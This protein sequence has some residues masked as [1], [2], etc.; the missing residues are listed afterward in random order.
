MKDKKKKVLILRLGAIGD[1]VHTTII[2]EA[3]KQKHP[4][5][6]VHYMTE[7]T[8]SPLLRNNPY[9]DKI[10][11]WDRDKKDS[12]RYYIDFQKKLLKERYDIIF[13]L[14]N[15]IR[16]DLYAYLSFP[17]KVV[18]KKMK[19]GLW[20]EDYFKTAQK[21][22]KDIELPERLYLGV[23]EK[24]DKNIKEYLDAYPKP[25]IMIV[26]GGGT[27]NNRQGRVW[28][29]DNWK[30]LNDMLL[31]EYGGTIFT[32]GSK[33][34]RQLHETLKR[35]GVIICTGEHKLAE[36]SALLSHAD[37]VVSGDTGPLHIASAHNVPTLALL[38]STSPDK[39]KPYGKNGHYISGEGE[40]KY[41]WKKKC[42]YLGQESTYTPCMETISPWMVMDKI[43]KMKLLNCNG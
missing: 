37:L 10:Y 16:N 2:A 32:I 42:T 18:H 36:S 34:E 33:K 5:Y 4:N 39:I 40:C 24:L 9:I 41:C 7:R 43:I 25:H 12:F 27:N 14:T 28:N 30:Q 22:I 11:M 26:P 15:A 23:D 31:K 21:V 19:S 17:K 8:I 13:N 38:G 3:I 29:I 1:V 35:E 6:E 20:V